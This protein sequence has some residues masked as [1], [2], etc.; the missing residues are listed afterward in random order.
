MVQ[1]VRFVH[2]VVRCGMT[3][4]VVYFDADTKHIIFEL[5]RPHAAY[6]VSPPKRPPF[7]FF[8]IT[9]SKINRF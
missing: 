3:R 9:A 2:S 4:I 6:P 5:H 8:C 1:S 7:L